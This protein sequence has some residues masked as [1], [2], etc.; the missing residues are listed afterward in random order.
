MMFIFGTFFSSPF[1][2]FISSKQ[3]L[4]FFFFLNSLGKINSKEPI[5]LFALTLINILLFSE[6]FSIN[7]FFSL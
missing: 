3:L 5:D 2:V 7:K 1:G 6:D 4:I